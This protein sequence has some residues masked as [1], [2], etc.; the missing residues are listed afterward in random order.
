MLALLRAQ[1]GGG[2]QPGEGGGATP[3]TGASASA[4]SSS[5]SSSSSSTVPP[6]LPTEW[7]AVHVREVNFRRLL[8]R[9]E[10]RVREEGEGTEEGRGGRGCDEEQRPSAV[11]RHTSL[12]K[13][14]SLPA[15]APPLPPLCSS[16]PLLRPPSL[17]LSPLRV[18]ALQ[19]LRT[20]LEALQPHLD[21]AE[22]MSAQPHL[23]HCHY[24]CRRR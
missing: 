14:P 6:F 24:H 21:A 5:S 17:R 11:S 22:L 12:L 2:Q 3:S 8:A 1:G 18:Q 23:P 9:V 13:V 15:P 20:Q 19:R 7:S 16:S 4:A 10:R